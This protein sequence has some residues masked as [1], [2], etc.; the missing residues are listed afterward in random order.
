MNGDINRGFDIAEI[1]RWLFNYFRIGM[2]KVGGFPVLPG[3]DPPDRNDLFW[4]MVKHFGND[5]RPVMMY[6]HVWTIH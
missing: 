3:D 1:E 2:T 6:H 5:V 4:R